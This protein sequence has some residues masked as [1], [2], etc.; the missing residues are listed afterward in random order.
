[1]QNNSHFD[2]L[3]WTSEPLGDVP[4]IWYRGAYG[5]QSKLRD[6]KRRHLRV[7]SEIDE[8]L[9]TSSRELVTSYLDL[10]KFSLPTKSHV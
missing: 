3:Y 6:W 8:D 7:P 9:R 1:M 5:H 2:T 10:L 4:N